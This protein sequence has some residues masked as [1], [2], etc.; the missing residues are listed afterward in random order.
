MHTTPLPLNTFPIPEHPFMVFALF[1][2][3]F[4]TFSGYSASRVARHIGGPE[5]NGLRMTVSITLWCLVLILP[6]WPWP[7]LSATVVFMISGFIHLGLGDNNLYRSYATI[8][9]RLGALICISTS[10]FAAL[11]IERLTLGGLPSLS[12]FLAIALMLSGTF[13]ALMP[14]RTKGL[15]LERIGVI[16]AFAAGS[17]QAIGAVA[18][19][20]AF[21]ISELPDGVLSAGSTTFLR[22]AG[23]LLI[24]AVMGRYRPFRWKKLLDTVPKGS[25]WVVASG[26]LGPVVGV[27]AYQCALRDTHS[28]IVQAVVGT[29]P[30]MMIPLTWFGDDDRPRP[31]AIVG[32]LVGVLG[33]L[34]LVLTP[35]G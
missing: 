28:G 34:T 29:M 10:T 31:I 23:A 9:P 15:S 14:S 4:W 22:V 5:T 11:V 2:A 16:S 18:S 17:C 13:M 19:R 7:S 27:F 32:T 6:I 1:T 33:I 30:L 35:E 20:Y 24:L 21:S 26:V 8:G 25:R 12:Q 3:L